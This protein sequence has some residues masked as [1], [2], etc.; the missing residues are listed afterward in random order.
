MTPQGCNHGAIVADWFEPLSRAQVAARHGC[1]EK[2]VTRVWKRARVL[3]LVRGSRQKVQE[4]GGER[5]SFDPA[6]LDLRAAR[7]LWRHVVVQAAEDAV[8]ENETERSEARDWFL[9]PNSDFDEA[10]ELA[11]FEAAAVRERFRNGLIEVEATL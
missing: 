4:A 7:A 1:S 5:H 11:G 2:T 3:G 8:G 6:E 10:C 9:I